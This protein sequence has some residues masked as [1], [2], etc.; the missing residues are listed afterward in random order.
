MSKYPRWT[1]AIRTDANDI[2]RKVTKIVGLKSGF[3]VLTPYHKASKGYICKMPIDPD[4]EGDYVQPFAETIGFTSESRVKLTYHAD[5]FVQFSS[6]KPGEVISGRDP[7]TGEPKGCALF[8]NPLKSPIWSGPSIA[9]TFWGL[10]DFEPLDPSD[11]EAIIFEPCHFYYRAC[12]PNT[13]NCW[14]LDIYIF[15]AGNVPP[16]RWEENHLVLD[17][18]VEPLNPPLLSVRRFSVLHLPEEN[19]FLGLAIN[20]AIGSAPPISG[21]I[22]SGPGDWTKER[23]GHVLVASYPREGIPTEGRPPLDRKSPEFSM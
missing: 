18:A 15:P 17:A 23:K 16:C 1:V 5:G 20:S 6:E 21:W 7:K 12:S 3:S 11:D 4:K 19:I 22:L 8:T 13:A 2:A 10:E 9:I 14:V